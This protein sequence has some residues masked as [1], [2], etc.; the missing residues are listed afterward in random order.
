MLRNTAIFFVVVAALLIFPAA[1]MADKPT[2]TNSLG[3][4]IAWA[5]SARTK[6]Q[7]GTLMTSDG[8]PIETGYDQWSYNY[9]AHIF[10]GGYCDAYRNAPWCQPYADVDLIMKWND[11]WLSNVDCDGDGKLDRH[12]PYLT[13]KGVR[14][15]GDKPSV[16]NVRAGWSDLPL[17]LLCEDCRRAGECHAHRWGMVCSRWYGNWPVHLG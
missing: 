14:C 7:D 13:Y 1:G 4:E 9:Q 5:R 3:E 15:V 8:Y 11:A 12:V 2:Q 16:G 10:N 17:D 6:I